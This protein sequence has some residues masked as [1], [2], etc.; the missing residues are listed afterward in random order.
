MPNAELTII[1]SFLFQLFILIILWSNRLAKRINS[2][3]RNL[4]NTVEKIEEHN[5][6]I[7]LEYGAFPDRPY[8][9]PCEYGDA[10]KISVIMK[11]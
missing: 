8:D 10:K 9:S 3:L 4:L 2:E 5:L 6:D 7:K 1:F 11:G